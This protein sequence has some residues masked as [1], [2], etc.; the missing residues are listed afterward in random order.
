MIILRRQV[1]KTKDLLVAQLKAEGVSYD[2]RMRRLDEVTHPQPC[3]HFIQIA[4]DYFREQHPWVGGDLVKPKSIAREM[5]EEYLGFGDYVRRYGLQR[6][7]GVLLRYLSQAYKTLD[8]NVPD[9]VKTNA[10]W[11]VVGYLRSVLER[12]D[13][14]LIEEWEALVHP[15]LRFQGESPH[16]SHHHLVAQELIDDPRRLSS[17][18]RAE[19]HA[20]VAALSRRQWEE[21]A[22]CVRQDGDEAEMWSSDGF[23]KAL[24]PFFDRYNRLVFDHQARLADKTRIVESGD[25][26]WTANQI[27][28][29]PE[30]ENLW[31]IEATINLNDVENLEGPIIAVEQ[32][33]T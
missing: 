28:V 10:V 20:L 22:A 6:S 14:S 27:L 18:V 5:V 17:R 16:V 21:A 30:G 19:L 11:D 32:I 3:A 24:T 15:E 33:G 12:T 2:E 8:Q 26:S 9:G 23:E 1:A 4:F 25:L 13:T 31:F 29:D 7:E